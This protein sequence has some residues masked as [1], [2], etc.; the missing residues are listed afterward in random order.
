[1]TVR[2]PE[3]DERRQHA[4]DAVQRNLVD[5]LRAIGWLRVF[6]TIE[7]GWTI[8]DGGKPSRSLPMSERLAWVSLLGHLEASVVQ[9]ALRIWPETEQGA[10][11]P[12]PAELANM[13]SGR[14]SKRDP[15]PTNQAQD[16][17]RDQRPEVLTY[18]ADL[19][20]RGEPVC[21]C[22]PAPMTLVQDSTHVLF[23]PECSGI[24]AGHA[25]QALEQQ[26]PT[27]V[28]EF[29]DLNAVMRLKKVR[30]DRAARTIEERRI[31]A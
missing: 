20:A 30:S 23:C 11:C 18:V 16:L 28:T 14:G 31:G 2:T 29:R 27:P 4:I 17:R 5:D 7:A 22:A 12:K 24:E 10:Y 15:A 3:E 9:S 1:M 19:V 21:E 25:D 8:F 13:L 26:H 6:E